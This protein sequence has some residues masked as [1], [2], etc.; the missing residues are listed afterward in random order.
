MKA[1]TIRGVEREVAEK[2]RMIAEKNG[3]S[4]NQIVLDIIKKSLGLEKERKHTREYNDLDTLFGSWSED[5]FTR[6]H[7]KTNQERQIDQELWQ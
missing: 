6:I 7:G 3:K 2:L 5:D 1:I 4:I